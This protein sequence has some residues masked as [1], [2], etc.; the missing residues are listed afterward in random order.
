MAWGGC[1]KNQGTTFDI[2]KQGRRILFPVVMLRHAKVVVVDGINGTNQ[3]ACIRP[4]IASAGSSLPL[5][6]SWEKY[7][8]CGRRALL[9][10]CLSPLPF[11]SFAGRVQAVVFVHNWNTFC[12]C[13]L[14]YLLLAAE[15]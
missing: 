11:L 5:E 3:G 13:F 1:T 4:G 10:C 15:C 8:P 6:D 12:C 9:L 7:R 2:K 14:L